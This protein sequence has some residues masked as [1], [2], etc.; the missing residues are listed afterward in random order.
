MGNVVGASVVPRSTSEIGRGVLGMGTGRFVR[1]GSLLI[2][3]PSL[4]LLSVV[5]ATVGAR[6]GHGRE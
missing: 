1:F 5:G 3:S 2:I 4:L 6:V